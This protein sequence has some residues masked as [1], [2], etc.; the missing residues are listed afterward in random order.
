MAARLP[1]L[2][3]QRYV[4]SHSHVASLVQEEGEITENL[5]GFRA[6]AG[7]REITLTGNSTPTTAARNLKPRLISTRSK[8]EGLSRPHEFEKRFFSGRCCELQDLPLCI[9]PGE[10]APVLGREARSIAHDLL[11][12]GGLDFFRKRFDHAQSLTQLAAPDI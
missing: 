1:E 10:E 7:M 3:C 5:G 2:W 12:P 4:G 8:H 9:G 11:P 6:R